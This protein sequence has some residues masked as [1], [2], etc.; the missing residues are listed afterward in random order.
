MALL[1]LITSAER[2]TDET[3][4]ISRGDGIV[5]W[6]CCQWSDFRGN[7]GGNANVNVEAKRGGEEAEA[8]CDVI[9]QD[10]N[11]LIIAGRFDEEDA[12]VRDSANRPSD[13]RS[14]VRRGQANARKKSETEAAGR[15]RLLFPHTNENVFATAE[16][17]KLQP[18]L[19]GQ[20][21]AYERRRAS[22][23][24]SWPRIINIITAAEVKHMKRTLAK[25]I[26]SED[27]AS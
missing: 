2:A 24:G 7:V 11:Q 5:S 15:L 19:V 22:C 1:L 6:D 27:H 16:N 17:L 9:Y 25:R 3:T 23:C 20:D 14:G 18:K 13:V 10:G 12:Y 26:A 21:S 4:K 8:R